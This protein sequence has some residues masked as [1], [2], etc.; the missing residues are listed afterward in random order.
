MHFALSTLDSLIRPR[1]MFVAARHG[2]VPPG[3]MRL[4]WVLSVGAAICL[5]GTF[6][7]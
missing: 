3:Y 6:L 1:L 5:A 7:R 2:L 4:R